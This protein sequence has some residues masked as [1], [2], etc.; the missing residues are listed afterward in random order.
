MIAGTMWFDRIARDDDWK[1]ARRH[2]RRVDPVLR[3]VI[4]RVGPCTLTSRGDPFIA[5]CQGVYSQQLSTK[6]ANVLF[7]RFKK[8][9]PRERPTPARVLKLFTG[10][11]PAVSKSCGLSRQK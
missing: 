4:D 3:K 8:L 11:D 6:V 7:S 5:L 10:C 2:L 1:A 9:F